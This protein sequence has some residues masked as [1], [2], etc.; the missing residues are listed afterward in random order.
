[1]TSRAI[2]CIPGLKKILCLLALSGLASCFSKADEPLENEG[3]DVFKGTEAKKACLSSNLSQW[4]FT[5][6]FVHKLLRC[7]ARQDDAGST[8]MPALQTLLG[9]LDEGKLQILID[10]LLTVDPEGTT[11]EEQHPYLLALASL[12]DRGLIDAKGRGLNLREERL[13]DLQPFLLEFDSQRSQAILGLWSRNGRLPAILNELGRFI[14]SLE[15]DSLEAWSHEILAGSTFKNDLLPVTQ[16][17]LSKESILLLVERSIRAQAALSLSEEARDQVRERFR[18]PLTA[19]D[20]QPEAVAPERASPVDSPVQRLV[21]FQKERTADEL[22]SMADVA[23]SIWESYSLL[24]DEERRSLDPRLVSAAESLLDQ[25]VA[26]L[27]WGLSLASDTLDLKAADFTKASKAM[28]QLL[29]EGGNI[30]LEAIRAKAGASRLAADLRTMLLQGAA[31]PGCPAIHADLRSND[32][33]DLARELG[34]LS[35]PQAACGGQ[36]PLL[37]AIQS[38]TRTSIQKECAAD[39]SNCIPEKQAQ[40]ALE[41]W[42]EAY[43]TPDSALLK[44]L[45]LRALDETQKRLEADRY[46]LYDLGLARSSVSKEAFARL[47]ESV[48]NQANWTVEGLAA[49]DSRLNDADDYRTWLLPDF[50]EGLLTD[51]IERLSSLS[52]QFAD[53]GKGSEQH[54]AR[55]FAG[56]YSDGPMEALMRQKLADPNLLNRLPFEGFEN[57]KAYFESHPAAWNQLLAR[58]KRADGFFRY[59]EFGTLNDESKLI[60]SNFGSSLRNYQ[61]FDAKLQRTTVLN[62]THQ[63]RITQPLQAIRAFGDG[64]QGVMAWGLWGQ[65]YANGPTNAKDVPAS[66]SGSL[67]TWLAEAFIPTMSSDAFWPELVSEKD[68]ATGHGIDSSFF[69]VESYS[70]A[71]A[72]LLA[73]Y[74][75]R[76]YRKFSPEL[77]ESA[78]TQ[79]KTSSPKTDL[80]SFADPIRG[81]MNAAYLLREDSKSE[82]RTFVKYFPEAFQAEAQETLS[83][84]KGRVLPE[85]AA[86]A[87]WTFAEQSQVNELGKLPFDSQ[88]PFALLSTLN[89]LTYSKPQSKFIPQSV[90]GFG[91]KLCRSKTKN[92]DGSF[93]ESPMSCPLEFSGNSDAEAYAKFR[94]Y[95]SAQ[96]AQFACAFIHD[97]ALGNRDIWQ[98]RLGIRLDK[99]DLCRPASTNVPED[100]LSPAWMGRRVLDDIFALGKSAKLKGGLAQIPSALRFYKLRDAAGDPLESWLMQSKG[101]WDARSAAAQRRREYFAGGFWSGQPSLLNSYSNAATQVV[102]SYAW[103][104]AL[105]AYAESD[106]NGQRLDLLR[107]LI[108]LFQSEQRRVTDESGDFHRFAFHFLRKLAAMPEH[109]RFVG[110]MI[111]SME[112]L[113]AYDFLSTEFPLATE[114]LF[115]REG[116]DANPFDWNDRGLGFFR[117]FGQ[118]ASLRSWAHATRYLKDSDIQYSLI[119]IDRSLQK[120]PGTVDEQAAFAKALQTDLD[121]FANLWLVD[122]KMSVAELWER[123]AQAWRLESFGIQEHWTR[124]ISLLD[125]PLQNWDKGEL[126]TGQKSLQGFIRSTIIHGPE[127][128]QT[129]QESGAMEEDL[130]WP[131]WMAALLK[132]IDG[133]PQGS[134]AVAAFL[135]DPRFDLRT[136]KIWDRLMSPGIEQDRFVAAVAVIENVPEKVWQAALVESA[137]LSARLEKALNYLSERA[138]WK[139][140]PEHNAFRIALEKVRQL[141]SD[142]FLRQKQNEV[143]KLWL[144]DEE[145]DAV[146]TK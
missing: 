98:A 16:T 56:L 3:F 27:R 58:A 115:P 7:A 101:V 140:D 69:D 4:E 22:Q 111:G 130:F 47:K 108:R 1:M 65:H 35:S 136:G 99:A 8:T 21:T 72:R 23:V 145:A 75:L 9:S 94:E 134:L 49:F 57:V 48:A 70:P 143:L 63:H 76:H 78:V 37:L 96:A 55:I 112:S 113:E 67:Q 109:M 114:L 89:L 88:S 10:F 103:R 87:D 51:K 132:T 86:I 44:S 53:L 42:S 129:V 105:I 74:Y 17:L 133:E 119:Q 59:P 45:V 110:N 18:D 64:D 6:S 43:A 34:R 25:Q 11:H 66:L 13:D 102:D 40:A 73:F 85:Q 104:T 124:L 82:F 138:V 62:P 144:R 118:T 68:Q 83:S 120:L 141:S 14:E 91:N 139:V 71:E 117:Y 12:T 29:L 24:S 93:V 15:T 128:L 38:F 46:Y 2:I 33:A 107:D 142:S 20:I 60:F 131:R 80:T 31:I 135:A 41:Y 5:G 79:G 39:A 123:I 90:V 81:F 54:S 19:D 125:K 97:D 28:D 137:D 36:A 106:A 127:L 26:P 84:F 122:A 100:L 146:V 32:F 92:S 77:P 52:H 61:S 126:L 50:L 116:E 121:E 95:V 30:A